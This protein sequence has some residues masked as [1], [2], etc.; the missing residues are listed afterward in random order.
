[1]VTTMWAVCS[2]YDMVWLGMF[3][4]AWSHTIADVLYIEVHKRREKV[5]GV[6]RIDCEKKYNVA[7]MKVNCVYA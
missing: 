4:F 3:F 7:T 6:E 2:D 1:M 5:R